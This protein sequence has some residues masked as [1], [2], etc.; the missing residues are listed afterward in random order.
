MNNLKE[1]LQNIVKEHGWKRGVISVGEKN[2][3]KI[4]FNNDPREYL[5]LFNDLDVVQSE[6]NPDCTLFR[7]KP[8]ENLIYYY[9]NCRYLTISFNKIYEVLVCHF[10]LK[11]TIELEIVLVTWLYEVYNIDEISHIEYF[12][13][14]L[15]QANL[16]FDKQNKNNYY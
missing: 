8:K 6:E 13:D 4:G 11:D 14:Y 15:R 16:Q 2:L 12:G 10:N 5:N 1:K 9:P 3:L 7:Y